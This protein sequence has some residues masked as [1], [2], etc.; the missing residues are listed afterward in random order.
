MRH[1]RN[2]GVLNKPVDLSLGTL[3][4][5]YCPAAQECNGIY[6]PRMGLPIL[7]QL[8]GQRFAVSPDQVAVL[9][10]ASM[11]LTCCILKVRADRCLLL[12]RPGF[13]AYGEAARLLGRQVVQYDLGRNWLESLSDAM[14]RHRPAAVLLNSP[15]NPM[16]NVIS[17]EEREKALVLAAEGGATVILDETYAGLEFPGTGSSGPLVGDRPGVIRVGSFSKSF[18]APGLRIGYAIGENSLTGGI[19]DINWVL[20]MS[21]GGSNQIAAAELMM[22]DL[23]SPGR[24]ARIAERLQSCCNVAMSALARHGIAATPPRGGPLLWVALTG[25][26]GRGADLAAH[27]RK[28][29]GITVTPGEAFGHD[30][31]PAIRCCYALPPDQ[32]EPVFDRLGAA[33]SSYRETAGGV[34]DAGVL[35][36]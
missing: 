29:A 32:V 18:C 21:P 8:I 17:D 23:R 24:L 34:G 11:A 10:G 22:D 7:R 1:R 3:D 9:A 31:A 16:G 5:A 14:M 4:P 27:C 20:A 2:G 12:P 26:E 19:A 36:P 25:K 28:E 6:A 33:L 35:H 30:G 15:G 13:P